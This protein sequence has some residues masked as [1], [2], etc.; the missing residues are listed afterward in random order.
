[1]EST[2]SAKPIIVGLD[3]SRFSRAALR[4]ALTEGALRD[5]AVWGLMIAHE[6]PVLAAGRPTTIGLGT[7]LPGEPNPEYVALLAS[8]VRSIVGEHQDPRLKADLVQGS[9]PEALCAASEHAQLLVLGSRGHGQAFEA[10][11][12]SVSQYCV[13]HATCPVV[14]IPARVAEST[15]D[16]EP[17]RQASGQPADVGTVPQ[18]TS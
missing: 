9:P 12:G 6:A 4:W 13:R 5:C 16:S 17:A 8:T 7:L 1:M 18:P 11:L 3:G 10:V 14:V 15:N 2:M